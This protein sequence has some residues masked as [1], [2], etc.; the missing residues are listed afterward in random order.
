MENWFIENWFWVFMPTC[1]VGTILVIWIT[2]RRAMKKDNKTH[3]LKPN[4]C[5]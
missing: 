5:D 3:P 4:P 2:L 1:F